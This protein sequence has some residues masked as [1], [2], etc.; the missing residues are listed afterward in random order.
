LSAKIGEGYVQMWTTV[1]KG[2]S[3]KDL[4]D[5]RKLVFLGEIVEDKWFMF[6][7]HGKGYSKNVL[8]ECL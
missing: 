2:W 7:F 8:G 1:E 4:L 6:Q 5:V 3:E